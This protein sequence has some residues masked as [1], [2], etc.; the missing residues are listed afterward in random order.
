MNSPRL[1]REF[2]VQCFI[3]RRRYRPEAFFT[4]ICKEIDPCPTHTQHLNQICYA[5]FGW[6]SHCLVHKQL[7]FL[8]IWTQSYTHLSQMGKYLVLGFIL[9]PRRSLNSIY[10]LI[11]Y[12]PLL[13]F[14]CV[15]IYV[16]LHLKILNIYRNM[17]I[18]HH[19]FVF[20]CPSKWTVNEHR[21]CGIIS[22]NH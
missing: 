13:I 2:R 20:A 4:Q 1:K 16:S 7:G 14:L 12:K 11:G 19:V 22:R 18:A 21:L 5:I 3:A 8:L 9:G 6:R 17:K 15:I 10:Y